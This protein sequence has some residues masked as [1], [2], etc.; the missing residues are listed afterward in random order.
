MSAIS[1]TLGI[2]AVL[3]AVGALVIIALV[4]FFDRQAEKEKR[5]HENNLH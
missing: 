4:S 2:T 3:L 5:D 1:I